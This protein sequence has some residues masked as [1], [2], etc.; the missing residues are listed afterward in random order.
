M[1]RSFAPQLVLTLSTS[2]TWTLDLNKGLVCPHRNPSLAWGA[3]VES[4]WGGIWGSLLEKPSPGLCS[5]Y[6]LDPNRKDHPVTWL[7]PWAILVVGSEGQSGCQ[8]VVVPRP[9]H[10]RRAP[11]S[12]GLGRVTP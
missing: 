2:R 4:G 1:C 12:Q 11:L 5:G 9:P 8:V 10:P 3:A 7:S 6:K